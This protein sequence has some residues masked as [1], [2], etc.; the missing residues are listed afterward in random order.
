MIVKANTNKSLFCEYHNGFRHKIEDCYDLWDA[1]EQLTWEGRLARYIASQQSSRKRRASSMKEHERRNPRSQKVSNEIRDYENREDELITRTINV[2]AGRFA[3]GGVT[4]S[5]R[6]EHLQKVLS[7][8]AAK[9]KKVHKPSTTPENCVF[10]CRF[11]G[12][13]PW[14]WRPHGHFG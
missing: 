10:Q 12:S 8:S 7:L 1:V 4:K 6:K 14:T 5:A 3:G 13:C 11:R 9:M 2:I